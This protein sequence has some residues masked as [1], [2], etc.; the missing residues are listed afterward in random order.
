MRV[1]SKNHQPLCFLTLRQ[2]VTTPSKRKSI[3]NVFSTPPLRRS[4]FS[5]SQK[6]KPP[7]DVLALLRAGDAYAS[8]DDDDDENTLS[9]TGDISVASPYYVPGMAGALS[10]KPKSRRG[11]TPNLDASV[12]RQPLQRPRPPVRRLS[13]IRG[14]KLRTLTL[15]AG[16]SPNAS[17]TPSRD[18]TGSVNIDSMSFGFP[19]EAQWGDE[20]VSSSSSFT[21]TIGSIEDEDPNMS[22]PQSRFE[23]FMK[24]RDLTRSPQKGP[25]VTRRPAVR[26]A[27]KPLRG[28]G[29]LPPR[30]PIPN[31][32]AMEVD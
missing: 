32:G 14:D 6:N 5:R 13:S 19:S 23:A 16:A 9:A 24:S 3:I 25:P 21:G 1:R 18:G 17:A 31:W 12:R 20:S 28:N 4:L 8:D 30:M 22:T 11:A 15:R 2:T 27:S 10:P 26:P 7:V 29:R